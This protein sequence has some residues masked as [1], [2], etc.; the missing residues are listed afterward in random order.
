MFI[1]AY[2]LYSLASNYI[3]EPSARWEIEESVYFPKVFTLEDFL[4]K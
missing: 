3:D 4:S 2:F 1:F